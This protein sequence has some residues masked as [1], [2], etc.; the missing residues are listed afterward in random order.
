M[1]VSHIKHIYDITHIY[2][3]DGYDSMELCPGGAD[4]VCLVSEFVWV[5]GGIYIYIYK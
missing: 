3:C 5:G 1:D 4:G 2:D